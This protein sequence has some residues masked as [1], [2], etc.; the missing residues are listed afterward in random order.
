MARSY[1]VFNADQVDGFTPP[2]A[3]AL[4]EAERIQHAEAFLRN[5]GADIRHGGPQA[6]YAPSSDHIQMPGFAA[7][8]NPEAYYS[9]MGHELTHWSGAP[10]RLDRK[11]R[12]RFASEDYAYEELIAELGAAY[13]MAAL[14]LSNEPRQE[15]AAYIQSWLKGLRGDKRFI[16]SAASQA[17]QAADYLQGLQPGQEKSFTRQEDE[18][19]SH[20][21]SREIA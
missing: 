17:Q 19:R 5:T 4:P 15:H 6:F 18:R 11:I 8:K 9:T 12:N 14:G 7:F 20:K 2:L 13:Q 10:H 16:F 3:P 21:T 1:P